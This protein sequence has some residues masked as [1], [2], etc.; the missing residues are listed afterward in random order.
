VNDSSENLLRKGNNMTHHLRAGSGA[1]VGAG[2]VLRVDAALVD[3]SFSIHE[4]TLQPG[5]TVPPHV[6][7]T[8]DQLLYIVSGSVTATVDGTTVE[9]RPGDFVHKPK[10]LPHTF[11]NATDHVATVLE[12]TVS[13]QFQRFTEAAAAASD[14]GELASLQSEHGIRF[15][16]TP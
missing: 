9:A 7:E 13:D 1:N 15:A 5:E 14:P 3:G 11:T 6:H 12:I 16:V 8:A 10:G 2:L 4:G